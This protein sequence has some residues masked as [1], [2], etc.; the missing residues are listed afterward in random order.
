MPASTRWFELLT[1]ATDETTS[2]GAWC[3]AVRWSACGVMSNR[4]MSGGGAGEQHNLLRVRPARNRQC[5]LAARRA[6]PDD[7]AADDGDSDESDG[8]GD[9]DERWSRC[10]WHDAVARDDGR[11]GRADG[12]GWDGRADDGADGDGVR[13]QRC[14]G[15]RVGRPESRRDREQPEQKEERD[16]PQ[17]EDVARLDRQR[18][19]RHVAPHDVV[20]LGRGVAAETEARFEELEPVD[21]WAEPAWAEGEARAVRDDEALLLGMPAAD[22]TSTRRSTPEASGSYSSTVLGLPT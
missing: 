12:R 19:R 11:H 16:H 15:G 7:E 10:G 17:H 1:Y 13:V 18:G 22:S 5:D 20:R 2:V 6:A 21:L 8:G 14:D 4:G 9:D 3:C